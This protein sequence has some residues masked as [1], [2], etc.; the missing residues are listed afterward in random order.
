MTALRQQREEEAAAARA[1]AEAEEARARDAERLGRMWAS[2]GDIMD[3]GERAGKEKDAL[4]VLAEQMKKK[5]LKPVDHAAIDYLPI[6][7]NLYIVPRALA[8][9]TSEQVQAARAALEIKIRGKGCPPPVETW[10]QCGLRDRVLAVI[11]RLGFGAPFAIQRQALPALMSGRDVIGVA[12]TG[13]GKTLAFLLPLFRHI[14]DQPPLGEGEGP[15]GLIMAPARELAVQI[16]TEAKK[17]TKAL[18]LRVTAVYGGAM[19]ADQIGDL[20]RGAEI[21]VCTP[22]RMIDILT[23]QAGKLVSLARVSFV[24]MDEADRMFDMGF[25]PQIRMILQNVRPDRQTALFSATFPPKVEALARKVLRAPL[26]IIVGG[27]SVA[28]ESI[29]QHVE[30]REED[31][32]YMRLLQLLGVWY[33]RG[34]VLVFVDTQQ[35]ADSLFQDLT[36]SGYPALSLHGGKD[37]TDRDFTISDFKS[38]ARTLM[39][40]TSVAG[41]GLDVPDLVCV[42][43]YSCPNHLE[44][45]VHRVGRT[46]RAGRSGTAYT[47]IAPEE[48]AHAPT[49]VKALQAANQPVP[50]ELAAMADA[51]GA[52]VASGLARKA[53]SGFSGKGFTF[54]DAEQTDAQKIRSLEK[55]QYE[56]DAGLR[57]AGDLLGD[58]E[59]E[60][61]ERRMAEEESAEGGGGGGGGGGAAQPAA[62]GATDS[63]AAAVAAAAAAAATAA[64]ASSDPAVERARALAA[65]AA[66]KMGFAAPPAAAGGGAAAAPALSQAEALQQAKLI[67]QSLALGGRAPAAKAHFEET[68]DINDYP[69]QARW[70]VTQSESIGQV[71]DT[72]GVAI[73]RR[74]IYTP[75]GKKLAPGEEKLHLRIEGSHKLSVQN[76]KAE[77]Q[78]MLNEETLRVAG[79]Q[80]YGKYQVV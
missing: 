9:L 23:M 24:V 2:E 43:N 5:E 6:R 11:T 13:S 27:R 56:I 18:G 51:F 57:D 42:I 21:V 20:K 1:A 58:K 25:E 78:R 40:A 64:G 26:E 52:K 7:K 70:K 39:V 19:V 59:D 80:T 10:E 48:E 62:A 77:L 66:A 44:D 73:V 41:R 16:Y 29:T 4:A 67:A 37:Q 46:G 49:L 71:E 28:S 63:I 79:H 36:R 8:A 45:Y 12:R 33:E 31:D 65:A 50:P 68:I 38:K 32:K 54:D 60:E 76:A 22:G 72:M 3:E 47:F 55:R 35:K 53:N 34:N 61:A 30:V 69:Q 74:G 17:F 15:I 75:P 14:L